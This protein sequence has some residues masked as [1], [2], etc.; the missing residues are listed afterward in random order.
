MKKSSEIR[1]DFLTFFKNKQHEIV[2]SAPIVVKDD[3]TLLFTNAGMN[4][5]KDYFLGN[6]KSPFSRIADTQKCLRVSGKHNDLEEVGVDHYHHT[7]FE[8]LG[9]WS[10]GDYFKKEA[11]EYAWDLLTNIYQLDKDKLYV[12]YFEGDEKEVIPC[13]EEARKEWE[14]W[15][16]D[17]SHILKGNKKDN[18][19]EMGETG[20]CG[21]CSEIHYDSRDE[22]E[23]KKVPG[24]SLVNIGHP[25]VIEIWNLVFIQYQRLSNHSLQLLL[26]Q[27]VDMGMGFERL[28]RILQGKKSNYDTDI[29][30]PLIQEIEKIANAKYESTSNRKDIAFR[31]IADHIRA[32]CFCIADGQLPSNTGA[33]YVIRRILRR[34]VR[35]SYQV[36]A[37][38]TPL[39]YTLVNELAE[40][41]RTVF[42]ELYQQK[43]MVKKIVKEEEEAF[44]STID[45]GLSLILKSKV[46]ADRALLSDAFKNNTEKPFT[47]ISGSIAFELYDTYGFPF[48]LTKAIAKEY[49]AII[50]EAEFE[51]EFNKAMQQQKDRSRSTNKITTEDWVY[52]SQE[53]IPIFVG[54][55]QCESSTEVIKY[56]KINTK[57]KN[58]Y[59]WVLAQNPFYAESGGQIG[60]QGN[61]IMNGYNI[62]VVDCKK[63][64]S[65][66][67]VIT[68]TIPLQLTS[69]IKAVVDN[70]RRKKISQHHSATHLLHAALRKVL[71]SHVHQKGSL[72][73]ED[74]LRFDFAHFAKLTPEEIQQIE[75]IVNE[76]IIEN[77]PISICE[78]KKEQALQLGAMA[79]FGEKYA[80]M[81]RVVTI[82]PAF[83]VELCGGT[84]VQQT[85]EIGIFKIISESSTASGIRRIEAIT[86]LSVL[87][88]LK[89]KEDKLQSIQHLLGEPI[90]V[91]KYIETWM[92]EHASLKQQVESW[93]TKQIQA[94]KNELVQKRI[95]ILD[96]FFIGNCV[97]VSSP[98]Q[99]KAL[100]FEI[101]KE[102]NHAVIIL[103]TA[104][105]GKAHVIVI[106][107][108]YWTQTFSIDASKWI[109]EYVSPLIKGGGGG[110]K[111]IASA[112]GQDI[113][114]LQK[115]VIDT[116]EMI[117]KLAN[118]T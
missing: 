108:E 117:M 13:D 92:L 80:D 28:T 103:I 18:F 61:M 68:E 110:Q 38:K 87:A 56:R 114:H 76:K 36:L 11:I 60:D 42:P 31:V 40:Q 53:N 84:H 102:V 79:L 26:Q 6:K 111:T 75:L 16:K 116:Q 34:A 97:S 85:G 54:Y 89:N 65:I 67:I 8:M 24:A 52:L 94:I 100:A 104:I 63:E 66:P 12:T 21:P 62:S 3:P 115:I 32:I 47:T 41:T 83:S 25:E 37:I 96:G 19:W 105:Q 49:D 33:G 73:N 4:A 95:A 14:K 93:Q 99:L 51:A 7:M 71:G 10:F 15:I 101:K 35:Y 74:R 88:Y 30:M 109:K 70:K 90:D 17:S 29:F 55:N 57:G 59:Q 50:D 107:D 64:N 106:F 44:L 48:D 9:N 112:G 77:I 91:I 23:I 69:T 78:M 2:A 20:P 113:Q 45:K 86:G 22:E 58:M 43:D 81:V 46:I 82:D 118:K 27:H 1:Q 5:F 98:D 72:V 39:L